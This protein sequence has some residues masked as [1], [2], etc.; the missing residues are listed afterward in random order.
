MKAWVFDMDD[1]LYPEHAYARSGLRHV[2]DYLQRELGV[3]NAAQRLLAVLDSGVRGR[4]FDVVLEEAGLDAG[5]IGDL[6]RLYREHLPQIALYPDARAVLDDLAGSSPLA[7]ITDGPRVCQRRKIEALQ[8]HRWFEVMVVTDEAGRDR[9]KPHPWGYQAVEQALGVDGSQCVYL[10]D[11]P[12][13]D[14]ITAKSR[15]WVTV[16]VDRGDRLNPSTAP[17]A[18]HEAAFVV[19]DLTEAMSLNIG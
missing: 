15:G 11:N 10:G 13:K 6:V 17:S 19:G 5:I 2:G 4:I 12:T 7:L 18:Q 14:F 8:L 16:R 3:A 1:T 9:W